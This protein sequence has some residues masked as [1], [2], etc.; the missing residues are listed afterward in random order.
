MEHMKHDNMRYNNI[1]RLAWTMLEHWKLSDE[2]CQKS[3]KAGPMVVVRRRAPGTAHIV[4]GHQ[5][6]VNGGLAD[7]GWMADGP[8]FPETGAGAMTLRR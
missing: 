1:H 6:V 2:Y 4:A 5:W 3:V 7:P 8:G